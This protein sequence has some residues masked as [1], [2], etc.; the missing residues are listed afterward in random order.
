MQLRLQRA[1]RP[2]VRDLDRGTWLAY[3]AVGGAVTCLSNGLGSL[4]EMP[5]PG[6]LAF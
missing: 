4:E 3:H 2:A 1:Q 6:P 5:S